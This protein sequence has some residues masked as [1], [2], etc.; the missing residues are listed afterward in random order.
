M[1]LNKY[2]FSI[3]I[4]FPTIIIRKPQKKIKPLNEHS[5]FLIQTDNTLAGEQITNACTPVNALCI[6]WY[7]ILL[8][9]IFNRK[10]SKLYTTGL[11]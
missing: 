8:W 2:D 4:P 5:L 1:Y 10:V 11:L 6:C 9:H 7:S 3:S